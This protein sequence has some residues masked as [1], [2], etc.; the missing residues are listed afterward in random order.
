MASP[1]RLYLEQ[2]QKLC[3]MSGGDAVQTGGNTCDSAVCMTPV[4]TLGY[5]EEHNVVVYFLVCL[6]FDCCTKL[7]L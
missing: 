7:V 5:L 6:F 3:C 4:S 1:C 2:Q